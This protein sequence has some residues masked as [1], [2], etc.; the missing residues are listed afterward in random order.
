[1]KLTPQEAK[2]KTLDQMKKIQECDAL[3]EQP[4]RSTNMQKSLSS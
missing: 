1:M 2:E 3:W 4:R